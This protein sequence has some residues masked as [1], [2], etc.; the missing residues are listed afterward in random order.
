MKS[1]PSPEVI[2]WMSGQRADDLFTTT[3]TVAEILYGIEILPK[4]KRH[5]QLLQEAEATFSEDFVG[6]ILVFDQAAAHLY[7]LI[8]AARRTHGRPIG[9]PDA[10]IAAIARAHGTALATR[11]TDDFE[12]CGVRLINPWSELVS[13][14]KPTSAIS[15]PK[16]SV[17]QNGDCA[18]S[19]QVG[20]PATFPGMN[21]PATARGPGRPQPRQRTIRNVAR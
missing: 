5:D 4:G 14:E 6:R 16:E 13:Q 8:A 1:A 9:F 12:G 2:A 10:Q 20:S 7:P 3:I 15:N 11:D 19:S 18:S 21:Q 17:S